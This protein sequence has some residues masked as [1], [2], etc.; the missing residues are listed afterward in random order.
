MKTIEVFV[1]RKILSIETILN[2]YTRNH[3]EAPAHTNIL[4]MQS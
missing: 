3:T 2:A 1:K 4:T